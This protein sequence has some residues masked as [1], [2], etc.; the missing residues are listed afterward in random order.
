MS[1]LT[2]QIGQETFPVV[3]I[4]P[5][6]ITI[7]TDHGPTTFTHLHQRGAWHVLQS[8]SGTIIRGM[9]ESDPTSIRSTSPSHSTTCDA[10]DPRQWST[11]MSGGSAGS[12]GRII[13]HMPGRIIT[14]KKQVGDTVAL[15]E[16]IM[17]LEAMKM[18]ND[19]LATIT[20]TVASILVTSGQSVEG[21]S[22]LAD[23]HPIDSGA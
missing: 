20:G 21:G 6:T 22:L 7:S 9:I 2:I 10:H 15:G 1:Q 13:A 17:V 3:A 8:Q 5:T 16:S 14:V 12:S 11:S 4:T 19:I 18:Q 23:I